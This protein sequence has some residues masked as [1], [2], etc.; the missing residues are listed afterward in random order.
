[1]GKKNNKAKI[2]IVLKD[3]FLKFIAFPYFLR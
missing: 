3:G 2:T 1:M